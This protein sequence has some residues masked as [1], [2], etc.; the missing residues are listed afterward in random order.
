[1]LYMWLTDTFEQTREQLAAAAAVAAAAHQHT[2]CGFTCVA[3]VVLLVC[4]VQQILKER[5]DGACWLPA[6]T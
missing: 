6:V 1:M 3:P 5:T 2:C 4:G